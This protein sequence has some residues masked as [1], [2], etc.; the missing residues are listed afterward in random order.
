MNGRLSHEEVRAA[1]ERSGETITP[2][3]LQQIMAGLAQDGQGIAFDQF[4]DVRPL[5]PLFLSI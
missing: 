1:F 4:L 2:A 5:F 3:E